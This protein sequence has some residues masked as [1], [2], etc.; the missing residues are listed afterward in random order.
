[1]SEERDVKMKETEEPDVEESDVE[2]HVKH[3]KDS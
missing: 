2:A 1:M 3:G